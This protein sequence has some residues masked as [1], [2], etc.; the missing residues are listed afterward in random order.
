ML[1]FDAA[2][3]K[4]RREEEMQVEAAGIE[5]HCIIVR[6]AHICI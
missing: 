5:L 1:G 6:K 4:K 2:R 3:K